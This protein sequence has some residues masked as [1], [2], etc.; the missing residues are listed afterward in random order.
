[1]QFAGYEAA[2]KMGRNTS[3]EVRTGRTVS[4][5]INPGGGKI[6]LPQ[7]RYAVLTALH[8]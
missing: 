2:T 7:L 4:V 1:M 8:S 3:K 6:K 5:D